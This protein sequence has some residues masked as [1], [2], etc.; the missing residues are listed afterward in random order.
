LSCEKEINERRSRN[1]NTGSLLLENSKDFYWLGI[2][3]GMQL[4]QRP[5][6]GAECK[7]ARN[8][9]YEEGSGRHGMCDTWNLNFQ[10]GACGGNRNCGQQ[11]K[12][13]VWTTLH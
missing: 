4:A 3:M 5:N 8:L 6:N 11:R 7:A 13:E 10:N 9:S 1:A 2:S 12:Q